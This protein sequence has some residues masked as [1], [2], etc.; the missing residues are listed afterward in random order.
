M[1]ATNDGGN[2]SFKN[3][4]MREVCTNKKRQCTKSPRINGIKNK[5]VNKELKS[6]YSN[7]I[8]HDK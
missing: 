6:I 2:L 3:A 4:Q 1:Y 8:K 5:N 7:S